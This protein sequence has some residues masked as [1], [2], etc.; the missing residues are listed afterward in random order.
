MPAIANPNS[1]RP[2]DAPT[3]TFRDG[4]QR[5]RTLA[6][7]GVWLRTALQHEE[8]TRALAEGGSAVRAQSWRFALSNSPATTGARRS[9]ARCAARLPKL[10]SLPG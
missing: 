3:D 2:F 7:L 6:P 8:L 1:A 10:M 4:S 5:L 9:R